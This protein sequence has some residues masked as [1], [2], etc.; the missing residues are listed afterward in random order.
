MHGLRMGSQDLVPGPVRT[1]KIWVKMGLNPRISGPRAPIRS[2]ISL[3]IHSDRSRGTKQP[4]KLTQ[5]RFFGIRV[6]G[7][8]GFGEFGFLEMRVF[9]PKGSLR[10]PK[11]PLGAPRGPRGPKGPRG[12]RAPRGPIG[13]LKGLYGKLPIN[14]LRWRYVHLV[15]HVRHRHPPKEPGPGAT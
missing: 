4:R 3:R 15:R 14:H 9:G 5:I 13:P 1:T 11:G 8:S 7:N 6:F 12:P 10:A 2:K